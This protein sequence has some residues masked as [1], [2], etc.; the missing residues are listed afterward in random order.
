MGVTGHFCALAWLS[1]GQKSEELREKRTCQGRSQSRGMG[2]APVHAP[3]RVPTAGA[4]RTSSRLSFGLFASQHMAR[5]GK[6][7]VLTK[8]K[9]RVEARQSGHS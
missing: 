7:G 4:R 8:G 9:R 6:L 2:K 5:L 3:T 1:G